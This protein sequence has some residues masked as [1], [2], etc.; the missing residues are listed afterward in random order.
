M[1]AHGHLFARSKPAEKTSKVFRRPKI[2]SILYHNRISIYNKIL[3]RRKIYL[4]YATQ[5]RPKAE[6][7]SNIA[8]LIFT[9][10]AGAPPR[11]HRSL[12]AACG[13]QTKRHRSGVSRIRRLNWHA[14]RLVWLR[15]DQWRRSRGVT[16]RVSAD[17]Q[18]YR[19]G[20]QSYILDLHP[21]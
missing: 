18:C 11:P 20:G 15:S 6:T 16:V 5:P 12:V 10:K 14:R 17:P 13:I 4:I 8:R 9:H 7:S 3:S 2:L 1:S 21:I 19:G